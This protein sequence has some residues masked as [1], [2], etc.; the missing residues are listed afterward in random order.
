MLWNLYVPGTGQV[1]RSWNTCVKLAWD[2]PR[3]SHNYLVDHLLA[4]GVSPV[5]RNILGQ[6]L[7]FFRK[8]LTGDNPE[9]RIL[10][11]LAGVMLAQ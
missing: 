1:F 10:A 6:Y 9:I 3:W 4:P 2:V 8:L 11:N 5:R 7:G